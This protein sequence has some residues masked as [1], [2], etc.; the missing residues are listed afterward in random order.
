M[1]VSFSDTSLLSGSVLYSVGI[2]SVPDF[3]DVYILLWAGIRKCGGVARFPT[4]GDGAAFS[5]TSMS[6]SMPLFRRF[7][8]YFFIFLSVRVSTN[9]LQ[10]KKSLRSSALVMSGYAIVAV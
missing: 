3:E 9:S 8:S 5:G 6:P 2:D 1:K 4:I 7:F 10:R